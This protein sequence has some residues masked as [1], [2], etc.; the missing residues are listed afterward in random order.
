MYNDDILVRVSNRVFNKYD[1]L[2]RRLNLDDLDQVK[3][4]NNNQRTQQKSNYLAG[5][6]RAMLKESFHEEG[7]NIEFDGSAG[8]FIIDNDIVGVT[9][10][11]GRNWA[12]S[13]TSNKIPKQFLLKL[14]IAN[15]KLAFVYYDGTNG[16]SQ[17]KKYD[18]DKSNY[19]TFN[20]AIDDIYQSARMIRG[21]FKR[22]T[23]YLDVIPK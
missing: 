14:D 15:R 23:K 1:N 3:Y 18:N 6:M 5:T 9:I 2:L 11:L 17:W 20:L 8:G 13:K 7:I 12:G 10:T 22:C 21:D 19:S 4:A 16:K